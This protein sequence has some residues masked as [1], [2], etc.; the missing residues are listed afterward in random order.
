L[1]NLRSGAEVKYT[2]VSPREMD[3]GQGKISVPSVGKALV[4]KRQGMKWR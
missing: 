4:R 1:R 3:P 2:L